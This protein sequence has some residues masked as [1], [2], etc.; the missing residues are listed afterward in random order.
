M[1]SKIEYYFLDDGMPSKGWMHG[2]IFCKTITGNVIDG[3]FTTTYICKPC[4]DIHFQK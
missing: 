4:Y 1:N 2:C 3:K